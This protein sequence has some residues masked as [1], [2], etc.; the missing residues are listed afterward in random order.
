MDFKQRVVQIDDVLAQGRLSESDWYD[1]IRDLVEAAYLAKTSPQA[2]S[3]LGG[4]AAH[5]ERRR[6]VIADA[7]DRDGTFLDVGCASGLLTET[8][9]EWVEERGFRIEPYGLDISPKLAALARARLPHW[10][11]RVF[12]GNVIAWESP[13]RFDFVRTELEYVPH[14]RQADLVERLLHKMVA[15]GGRLVVCAY[16]PRGAGDAAPITS[17]LESWGFAVS[18]EATA[19]DNN[20]GVATRVV[21]LDAPR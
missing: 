12:V 20:G 7:F 19:T 1:Q 8:L 9:V 17:L 18:G 15:P 4:D 5:W 14:A 3:G 11:D 16:R 6:R 2:Q 13:R 10:A 21:W